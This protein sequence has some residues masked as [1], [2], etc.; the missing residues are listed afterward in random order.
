MTVPTF[1]Q[2][3]RTTQSGSAY[4]ANID[5]A[6]AV[7]ANPAGH[8]A[9]HAQSTP[10]MTVRVDAGKLQVGTGVTVVAAQNTATITA[11]VTNPRI[12]RV[13]IDSVTGVVSVIAGTEAASPTAP[14]ITAGKLAV[15]QILLATST[16]VI[17]N[18][19][20]TDERCVVPTFA[21]T[22]AETHSG[23]ETFVTLDLSSTLNSTKA[24]ESGYSR[25]TPNM[26]RI[27][28]LP[29]VTVLVRD[30]TTLVT[31]PTGSKGLILFLTTEAKSN[32]STSDRFVAITVYSDSAATNVITQALSKCREQVAVAAGTNLSADQVEVHVKCDASARVWL[33]LTDDPGNQGAGSYAI[34]GYYD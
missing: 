5:A 11:P 1:V 9:A 6:I 28:T 4:P 31:G 15:A 8:F 26:C 18:S 33:V 22:L 29:S 16:T 27:T 7:L 21:H 32:N 30:T 23:A 2:P 24:A 3:D 13:V 19:I 10:D 14:A 34:V 12:D 17:A 20:I 25:V